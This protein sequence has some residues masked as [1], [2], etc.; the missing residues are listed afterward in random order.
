MK[1]LGIIIDDK[2]KFS[3]HVSYGANKCA[4]LIHSL[5]RSDKISWGLEHEA[6][7]TIYKGSILPLF[8]YGAP[9]WIEVVKYEYN[10]RKYDRVQRLINV[11]MVKP[12]HK[13]SSDAMCIVTGRTPITIKAEEAVKKY[14]V[15]I[16]NGGHSQKKIDHDVEL[17]NWSHPADVL[18]I[19][20]VN[21]CKEQTIQV[22]TNRSKSE[23]GVGSGVA[24]FVKDELKAQHNYKLDNR[25]SNNQAE[26][27]AIVKELEM[28]HETNIE[29]KTP[30]HDRH[31]YRQENHY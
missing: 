7:K 5:P 6:L 24:T 3:Q 29:E 11:R 14:N 17:K 8:L 27:L 13:T 30:P 9:I 10:R 28:I 1:Y 18:H 20:E 22:Y 16:R 25:C 19:I 12:Y 2:F 23:H 21:G 26:Q 15:G 4:K 31:I